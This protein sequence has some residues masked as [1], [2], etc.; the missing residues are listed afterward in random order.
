MLSLLNTLYM[1]RSQRKHNI[2]IWKGQVNTK[3]SARHSRLYFVTKVIL[4]HSLA[5]Y[6]KSILNMATRSVC[7][8]GG[9]LLFMVNQGK[10][11]A[12]SKK[13]L[14]LANEGEILLMTYSVKK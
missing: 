3:L 5:F 8:R 6:G 12:S 2:T 9:L 10:I 11:N 4:W 13:I 7:G 14:A 1:S